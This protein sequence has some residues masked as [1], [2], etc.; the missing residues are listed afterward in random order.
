MQ[1]QNFNIQNYATRNTFLFNEL[2]A[3][4]EPRFTMQHYERSVLKLI[5]VGTLPPESP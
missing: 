4:L 3:N 5:K 1:C 2:S